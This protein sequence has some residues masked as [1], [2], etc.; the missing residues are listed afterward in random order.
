MEAEG[1]NLSLKDAGQQVTDSEQNKPKLYLEASLGH[2]LRHDMK[3]VEV[4]EPRLGDRVCQDKNLLLHGKAHLQSK[5]EAHC[6]CLKP[7]STPC[8][9]N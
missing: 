5:R 6:W 4:Q 8:S 2:V 1:L 9:C 3:V 7:K